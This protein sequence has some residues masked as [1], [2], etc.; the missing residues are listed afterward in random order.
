MAP[1]HAKSK[2]LHNRDQG[3]ARLSAIC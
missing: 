3:L 1:L 2:T